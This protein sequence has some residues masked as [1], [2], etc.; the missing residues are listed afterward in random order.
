MHTTPSL[1]T[2]EAILRRVS[3]RILGRVP[4][5]ARDDLMQDVRLVIW[6]RILPAFNPARGGVREYLTWAIENALLDARE[7]HNRA[8][9][10][11]RAM[12]STDEV[13]ESSFRRGKHAPDI[14]DERLRDA[15]M[16]KPS[17]FMAPGLA[18]L[19]SDLLKSP[20]REAAAIEHGVQIGTI[21]KKS[22]RVKQRLKILFAA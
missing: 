22:S 18:R 1:D 8:L 6:T 19:V 12:P 21:Y 13:D 3:R 9:K 4:L 17:E 20:D 11:E 10:R 15:I 2:A 7:K 5:S 14:H 16:T